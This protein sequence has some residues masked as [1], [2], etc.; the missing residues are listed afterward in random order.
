MRHPCSLLLAPML[1]VS[2]FTFASCD[3]VDPE[4]TD[5]RLAETN[6]FVTHEI[7]RFN[8]PWALAVE[9]QTDIIFVTGKKGGVTRFD[10]STGQQLKLRNV[11]EVDYGGQ[12]GMGDFIF[13]PDYTQSRKV[14]L[15]WVEAG[16]NNQRSAVVGRA[17]LVCSPQDCALENLDIIWRQVPKTTGRGHY[18]HRIAFA[19]DGKTLFIASG[20]RQKMSPAQSLDNNLGKIV[21]LTLDGQPAPGN[22]FS[23]QGSPADQVWTYGHRNILGLTFDEDGQ[24][25]DMEHGP[26]GGDELNLVVKGENYGWPI[27][28]EGEH[29]SGESI[30]SHD[31]YPQFAAPSLSWNPVIAPGDMTIYRGALFPDWQGDF[32]IASLGGP[33]VRVS[34]TGQKVEETARYE[35]NMRLRDIATDSGGAIWIIE[36]AGQGRLMQLTPRS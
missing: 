11:P 28:S 5:Y 14:Y 32:L 23:G 9:P 2:G 16:E 30:P 1:F 17:E 19:P 7:A 21:R 13:A 26:A 4:T 35:T 8:E 27:V 22:P 36:D 34:R 10:P 15:S 33:I 12:G 29:Y 31:E 18:S 25:W 20:D 6:P 24:L 3:P